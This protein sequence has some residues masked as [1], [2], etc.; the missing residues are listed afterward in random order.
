LA[1]EELVVLSHLRWVFVWQRPQHLISR[2]ARGRRSWFVEEPWST[3]V[4]RPTLR[5]EEH[6]PVT[7]VWLDVP[8]QHEWHVPFADERAAGFG[9]ELVRLLER[10]E[11]RRIVWLYT[12][13]ALDLARRL[14]PDLLVYDVMDD[15][16]SFAKAP[17]ELRER[18]RDALEAADLVFTGGRSLQ[19]GVEAIRPDAHLFPS[20]VEPEHWQAPLTACRSRRSRVAGYVGVVDERL[21]LDLIAGLAAALPDWELRLIG[22][23]IEKIDP[24][25]VPQAPNIVY[26]G[27]QPYERLPA[28]LAELDVALMP[29]ALNEATRSISPTKTLEYLAAGLPVVS[30][31]IADVVADF[32]DVVT[33]ADDAE[34]FAVA[35]RRALDGDRAEREARV[36]PLLERYR[37]D[38][39]AEQMNQLLLAAA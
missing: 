34:A 16:A 7:R 1:A 36:A 17:P 3:W 21:D 39:I 35:C 30:T 27:L 24:R 15:L 12:P 8:G 9:D 18:Q 20:G 25:S 11:G 32:G 26:T 29:F 38:S 5:T 22:P 33:L 14:G 4:G 19:R 37:W 23:V 10:R 6:E 28:L 13:M 2:L 31:R